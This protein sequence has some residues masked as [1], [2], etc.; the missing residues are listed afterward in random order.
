MVSDGTLRLRVATAGDAHLLWLWANDVE[1]RAAS[2]GRDPIP[3][4]EHVAWLTR[5]LESGRAVV[6]IAESADA[7]G[8]ERRQPLGSVRFD[9]ADGW[10]TAR[11]SYV[12]APE[13]RGRALSRPLIRCAVEWLRA[14]HAS[15]W[16]RAEVLRANTRSLRVFRGLSWVEEPSSTD[17]ITFWFQ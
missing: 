17:L 8:A 2:F 5:Q 11:L 14:T 16:V 7:D 3:W 6:L 12:V 10:T 9:T 13:S 1:T 15:V 4:P